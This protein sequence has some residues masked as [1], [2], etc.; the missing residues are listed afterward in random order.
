MTA[1]NALPGDSPRGE[2]RE[3][4]PWEPVDSVAPPEP[5]KVPRGNGTHPFDAPSRWQ[6]VL[7]A[8]CLLMVVALA[9]SGWWEPALGVLVAWLLAAG[10]FR[11][12]NPHAWTRARG[13]VFDVLALLVAAVSLIAVTLFLPT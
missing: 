4:L 10:V 11:A 3:A 13:R 6:V 1:D 5:V 12:V 7:W 8:G 2:P 9:I